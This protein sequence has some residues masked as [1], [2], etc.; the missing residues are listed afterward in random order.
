M[1]ILSTL[2]TAIPASSLRAI[3]ECLQIQVAFEP[4]TGLRVGLEGSEADNH[5]PSKCAKRVDTTISVLPQRAGFADTKREA[6]QN[7]MS[8][9]R[10][11]LIVQH[12]QEDEA[13]AEPL[14]VVE[15]SAE[16]SPSH[17]VFVLLIPRPSP[18]TPHPSFRHG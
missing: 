18:L 12:R 11:M 10:R 7:Q 14:S 15:G 17:C 13:P 9:R 2:Q 16:S 3:R 4:S 8:G 6:T 1:G 5:R